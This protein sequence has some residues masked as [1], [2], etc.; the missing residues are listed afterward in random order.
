MKNYQKPEMIENT[1][2]LESVY[3]GSGDEPMSGKCSF[4]RKEFNPHA[5]KCQR[6]NGSNYYREGMVCPQGRPA[7]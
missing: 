5:D 1:I 6:C 3:A 7:K 4:G 2:I